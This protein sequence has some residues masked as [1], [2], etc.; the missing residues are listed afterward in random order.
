MSRKSADP[1]LIR[2]ARNKALPAGAD[3]G[4]ANSSNSSNSSLEQ[5]SVRGQ[6]LRRQQGKVPGSGSGDGGKF[7]I[8]NEHKYD[9]GHKHHHSAIRGHHRS[10]ARRSLILTLFITLTILVAE[11]VG[12]LFT[13][14]LALLADAG[15]ML[16]DTSAVL[17]A[18]VALQL[19]TRPADQRRS[20]GYS[21]LEILAAL[22]NGLFLLGLA[23]FLFTEAIDRIGDPQPVKT[24]PMLLVASIGLGANLVALWLLNPSRENLNV[25][26]AFLHV[27]GDALSSLGVITGGAIMWTTGI[28]IIDPIITMV[29]GIIIIFSAIRLIREAGDILLES[30]PSHIDLGEV[31][32]NMEG[33]EGILNV[34]DLHIWS[35]TSDIFA[36]AAHVV[37]KRDYEGSTD[38]L[39]N[40]L[41]VM[42]DN[43]FH[44]LH[45]TIQVETED[46]L[47]LGPVC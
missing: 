42:L 32:L 45:T 26:G 21:R 46:Y 25:R 16:V 1:E 24:L 47:H 22:I 7:E 20:F 5:Q 44:I 36:L 6:M 11:I 40:N 30:V 3:E 18:V 31:L 28:Y 27:L 13:N 9:D 35:I 15:H 37:V 34:H 14:S 17:M 41:K 10:T 38:I 39:L 12:G 2:C 8:G 4:A 19:A 29:I 23:V 43:R 33:V